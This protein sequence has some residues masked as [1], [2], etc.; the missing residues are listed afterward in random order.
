MKQEDLRYL[1]IFH[2]KPNQ[3]VNGFGQVSYMNCFEQS[4]PHHKIIFTN[5]C[6]PSVPNLSLN[7]N[8]ATIKGTTLGHSRYLHCSS[9]PFFIIITV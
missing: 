7:L 3:K 5:D 9:S 6:L 2:F 1:I 8:P 4:E